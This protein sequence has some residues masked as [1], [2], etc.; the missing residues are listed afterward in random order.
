MDFDVQKVK[1]YKN[2]KTMEEQQK[3]TYGNSDCEI[4]RRYIIWFV[5]RKN[6]KPT[7]KEERQQWVVFLGEMLSIQIN[8][9]AQ[10]YTHLVGR[11][12][13]CLV[14]WLLC[15]SLPACLPKTYASLI[16]SVWHRGWSRRRRRRKWSLAA[17]SSSSSLITSK[18]LFLERYRDRERSGDHLT[19]RNGD[20]DMG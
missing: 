14:V 9:W 10:Q 2:R 11:Q 7:G 18:K 1:I 16:V 12:A 20:M 15:Y 4:T 5:I 17:A 8:G 19:K 13:D 3:G 6:K